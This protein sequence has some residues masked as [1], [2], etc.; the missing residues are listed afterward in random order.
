[1][2]SG[3]DPLDTVSGEGSTATSLPLQRPPVDEQAVA[4]ELPASAVDLRPP[5]W[6]PTH[7]RAVGRIGRR[8][9]WA[10]GAV[11]LALAAVVVVVA[12]TAAVV[13]VVSGSAR[14]PARG[15]GTPGLPGASASVLAGPG[16]GTA[17]GPFAGTPA[18]GFAA[19]EAG[20]VVPVATPVP[21]F[22]TAAVADVLAQ[23]KRALIAARL[24]PAMLV[25]RDPSTLLDLLAADSR[26]RAS[27]DFARGVFLS[28][29]SQIAPGSKLADDAPRVRGAMTFRATTQGDVR[30]L[31]VVSNVVWVYPFLGGSPAGRPLVVV[32]D[33]VV[34]L[35]PV[36]S[37][38]EPDGRGLWIDDATASISNVDCASLAQSLLALGRPQPGS[39]GATV[40]AAIFD[41]DQAVAGIP[42]C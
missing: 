40:E 27:S 9:V 33:E 32:H 21:G 41:P 4:V 25:D 35:F 22:S 37:D 7:R 31:E 34:W 12:V 20:I 10:S 2:T 14:G 13:P 38:V 16:P 42:T 17:V 24:D 18:A 19:G 30:L 23:V 1:M 5:G 36:P 39:P 8:T 26:G 15:A 3:S 29:A 11:V 6:R 28:Y